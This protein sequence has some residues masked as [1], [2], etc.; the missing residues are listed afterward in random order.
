[1]YRDDVKILR[2]SE[3][4]AKPLMLSN[5]DDLFLV[6]PRLKPDSDTIKVYEY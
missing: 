1:M 2:H 4:Y 3:V 6:L 5:K